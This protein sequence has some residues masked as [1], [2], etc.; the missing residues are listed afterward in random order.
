MEGQPCLFGRFRIIPR[1]IVL[2]DVRQQ[3]AAGARHISFGDPDF[4]NGPTHALRIVEAVHEELPE[5]IYDVTV[6]VEHLLVHAEL[7]PVL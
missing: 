1:E 2:G 4:F 7:L 6:K 5:L 3:V